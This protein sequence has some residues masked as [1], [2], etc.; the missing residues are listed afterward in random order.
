MKNNI[1]KINLDDQNFQ[2]LNL[3]KDGDVKVAIY[4]I[5]EDNTF[6]LLEC[7][8]KNYTLNIKIIE[9]LLFFDVMTSDGI[10]LIKQISVNLKSI[11]KILKEYIILCDSYYNA[12]KSAPVQ[13]VEA[14]DM[15][16]RSLHD[17]ASYELVDKMK[18]VAYMDFNTAR[19]FITLCSIIYKKLKFGEQFIK[20]N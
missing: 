6:Y 20:Y 7:A 3:E 8:E 4:D 11:I 18:K 13:K 15:G 2:N 16:R 19:R 14:L 12:I 10:K 1:K 17:D 9:N 5:L